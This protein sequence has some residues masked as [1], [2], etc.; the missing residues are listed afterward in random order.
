MRL[1][2]R[3]AGSLGALLVALAVAVGAFGAHTLEGRLPADRLST[4]E[5]S[6]RYQT[7]GGLG[8]LAM[9]LAARVAR[10][11]TATAAGGAVGASAG[12]ERS[13]ALLALG[14]LLFCGALYLLA[15]GGPRLLGLVAPLGGAAMIASWLWLAL[16]LWREPVTPSP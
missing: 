4:L 14:V 3:A 13:A 1:G 12:A 8:L 11:G 10:G 9:A 7:Y 5:T 2:P 15:A 6:V 16:S